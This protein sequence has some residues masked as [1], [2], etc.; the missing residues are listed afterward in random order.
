[1]Y[2]ENFG[3]LLPIIEPLDARS[4]ACVGSIRVSFH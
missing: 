4:L 1:M 2:A 3:V